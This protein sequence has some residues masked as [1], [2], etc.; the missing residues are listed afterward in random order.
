MLTPVVNGKMKR[1]KTADFNEFKVDTP[2][3]LRLSALGS[4]EEFSGIQDKIFSPTRME[5]KLRTAAF[6]I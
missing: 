6:P 4:M 2:A 5:F 3:E 1:I